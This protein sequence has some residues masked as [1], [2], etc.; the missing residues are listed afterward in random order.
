MTASSTGRGGNDAPA[1]FR[2]TIAR[3]PG[4]SAR[5]RATSNEPL[6]AGA[7]RSSGPLRRVTPVSDPVCSPRSMKT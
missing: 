2:W 4:V 6:E 3:Q 1:L 5:A 7:Q